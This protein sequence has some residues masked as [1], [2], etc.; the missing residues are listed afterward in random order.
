M[1]T[2]VWLVYMLFMWEKLY[3][4]VYIDPDIFSTKT[5]CFCIWEFISINAFNPVF[6]HVLILKCMLQ[7]RWCLH[8]N[9]S[10][11]RQAMWEIHALL[12]KYRMHLLWKMCFAQ[13]AACWNHR[14]L[15]QSYPSVYSQ[16]QTLSEWL[17]LVDEL[18][19]SRKSEEKIVN[20]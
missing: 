11:L 10:H 5:A 13:N 3:S 9:D 16:I 19:K 8:V 17:A 20:F 18:I 12:W 15:L 7:F 1:Q 6:H 4:Q 14:I 2:L